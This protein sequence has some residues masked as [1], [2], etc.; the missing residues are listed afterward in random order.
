MVAGSTV[1]L[2][3]LIHLILYFHSN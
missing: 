1:I 2:R 3:P